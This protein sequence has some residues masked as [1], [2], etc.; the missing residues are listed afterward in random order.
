MVEGFTLRRQRLF[1]AVGA[2]VAMLATRGIIPGLA[3]VLVGDDAPRGLLGHQGH[4]DG[5]DE[6]GGVLEV[7]LPFHELP[8]PRELGIVAV[9]AARLRTGENSASTGM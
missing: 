4:L 3:T 5:L 6:L 1:E 9:H 2:Q 8:Q 7:P